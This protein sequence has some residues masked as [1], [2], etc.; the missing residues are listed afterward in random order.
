[1]SHNSPTQ[2]ILN[3]GKRGLR[4]MAMALRWF[5]VV[6]FAVVRSKNLKL[7]LCREIKKAR[8]Q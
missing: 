4:M 2:H 5:V 3:I 7:E 1:M 6:E 8:K